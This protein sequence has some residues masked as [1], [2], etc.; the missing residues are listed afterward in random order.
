MTIEQAVTI[1]L[2]LAE[3]KWINRAW[4]RHKLTPEQEQA[5][6]RVSQMI[7]HGTFELAEQLIRNRFKEQPC[8]TQAGKPDQ[9]STND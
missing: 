9:A 7:E 2:K 4:R 1:V 6:R 3:S 5:I 8:P